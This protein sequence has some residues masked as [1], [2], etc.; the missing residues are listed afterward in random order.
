M[1]KN[2]RLLFIVF[3]MLAAVLF[4]AGTAVTAYADDGRGGPWHSGGNQG[5]GD[6]GQPFAGDH[7]SD[8]MTGVRLQFGGIGFEHGGNMP[9]N[10]KGP[11]LPDRH[12]RPPWENMTDNFTGHRLPDLNN[13]P[14]WDNTTDN[15]THPGLPD[16]HN[17]PP[18]DNMSDNF[19][20]RMPNHGWDSSDN[21]TGSF[22]TTLASIFNIDPQTLQSDLL[23]AFAKMFNK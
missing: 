10:F 18:S 13:R 22:I 2:S 15:F 21:R 16:W 4:I 6:G 14:P 8:N 20:G 23:Q 9:D 17:R 3:S 12:N 19:T 5:H 7:P 1:S 11:D